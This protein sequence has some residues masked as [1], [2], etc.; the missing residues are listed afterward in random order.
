MSQKKQKLILIP[1][2]SQPQNKSDRE[3]LGGEGDRFLTTLSLSKRI[4]MTI[5]SDLVLMESASARSHQLAQIE[6]KQA[7]EILTKIKS[8]YFALW[9]GTSTTVTEQVA[10]FYE[11]SEANLRNLV[12]SHRSEFASDGLKAIRGKDLKDARNLWLLPSR[13]SQVTIWT[14][15]AVLRA[16]ML[17][18]DS[19]VAQAVRT[20]L[21]N[22]VEKV[23]PA[24]VKQK[25]NTPALPSAKERLETIRLGMDLFSELGGCDQRT[26][27]LLK[28]Q[29][30]NIL[31]ADK[32]QPSPTAI[33]TPQ[34]RL[35]YPVSDRAASLGYRPSNR[36]LQQIG[37]QASR[38]YQERHGTKPIQREQFVGGA[39]R[40][41]NV[42][43]FSD[44]DLL[45]QAIFLVMDK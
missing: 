8:L 2:P 30:R 3:S 37:K 21:L 25:S 6:P 28:D 40:M 23:I 32:L 41:V 7:T 22:A 16:G 35:E 5:I 4:A 15:R 12:K 43:S 33:T 19:V 42:Y 13:T 18:R 11:V 44:V 17:M 24:Q 20:S 34:P 38:L 14:P 36:Q 27:L 9:E 31:L 26:Q 29:V 1:L 10:E 39:T 45:D